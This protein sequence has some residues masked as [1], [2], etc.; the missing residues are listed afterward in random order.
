M[1]TIQLTCRCKADQVTGQNI[2][3]DHVHDTVNVYRCK[4]DHVSDEDVHWALAV[5]KSNTCSL[6]DYRA[7][8]I[9]PTFAMINHSCINNARW[10]SPSSTYPTLY[11]YAVPK[12]DI[13]L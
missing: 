11:L 3:H 8:G 10:V 2:H 9:F 12:E 6:F 1:F 4:A 13:F 5:L 7:R